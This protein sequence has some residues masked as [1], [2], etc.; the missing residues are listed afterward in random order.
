MSSSYELL[1]QTANGTPVG[2]LSVAITNH[3]EFHLLL[4]SIFTLL[5]VFVSNTVFSLATTDNVTKS[6]L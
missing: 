3:V 2:C 4:F 5:P 6:T 1:R